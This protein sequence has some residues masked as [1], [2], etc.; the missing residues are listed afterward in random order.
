MVG[1][2]SF[3]FKFIHLSSFGTLHRKVKTLKYLRKES[4]RA[5]SKHWKC[6][7]SLESLIPHYSNKILLIICSICLEMLKY[8]TTKEA[9]GAIL[10]LSFCYPTHITSCVLTCMTGVSIALR[11]SLRSD[12]SL[13]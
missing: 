6:I 3:Q 11:L 13:Q 9:S 4:N 1:S 12:S 5:L 2:Y 7:H 10:L 8:P